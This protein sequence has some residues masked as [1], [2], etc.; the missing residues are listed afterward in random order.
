MNKFKNKKALALAVGAIMVGVSIV[1]VSAAC[2]TTQTTK[3]TKPN[4]DSQSQT[5]NSH[6][7]AIPNTNAPDTKTSPNKLVNDSIDPV[8]KTSKNW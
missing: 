4:Q 3:P 5:Q 6:D 8:P 1:S 7:P 2:K